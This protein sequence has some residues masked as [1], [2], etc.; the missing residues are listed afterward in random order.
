MGHEISQFDIPDRQLLVNNAQ[1]RVDRLLDIGEARITRT[2]FGRARV[3]VIRERDKK[4]RAWLLAALAV[5]ALAVAAWQGWI[6]FQQMQSAAPP[7]P[8][9]ARIRVGAPVFQPENVA[10]SPASERGK[11]ETLLQTEIDSLVASPKNA[12]KQ[13]RGL[14]TAGQRTEKPVTDQSLTT[15]TPAPL[16]TNNNSLKNQTDMQQPP[17][18]SDPM[19]PMAPAVAPLA[20]PTIKKDTSTLSPAGNN[21][22]SVPANTQP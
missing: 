14:N 9:S 8:L 5:I 6:A 7:L 16:A 19:Q 22:P 2:I 4:R 21:Q 18:L 13:P 1:P 15:S 11:S 17:R 20:E 10:P 3:R 12:P